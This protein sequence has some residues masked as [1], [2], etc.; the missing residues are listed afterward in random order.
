MPDILDW[1]GA[2]EKPAK[3]E[4]EAEKAAREVGRKDGISPAERW[5]YWQYLRN[6]RLRGEKGRRWAVKDVALAHRKLAEALADGDEKAAVG[7]RRFLLLDRDPA[8]DF[9]N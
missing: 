2:E 4:E 7:Y 3:V 5:A 9:E 8:R 6:W 1:D